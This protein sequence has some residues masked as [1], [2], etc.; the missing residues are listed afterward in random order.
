MNPIDIALQTVAPTVMV[1]RHEPF[2]PLQ[3]NGHRFLAA[4]DGLWLEARRPWLYL[5]WPLASQTKVAMPYGRLET[6]LEVVPV[7][8]QIFDQFIDM[9]Q[10]ACPLE[11]AA[12]VVWNEHTKEQ[13]LLP[14]VATSATTGSVHF[15]RPRLAEGEH[16]LLDLHSHG[17]LDAFFSGQ[18]DRD[19]RGE[20]KLSGVLGRLHRE[21]GVVGKFR[22]CANGLYV[23]LPSVIYGKKEILETL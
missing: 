19:D 14:M 15:D 17:R 21:I 16:L 7:L 1:P 4:A 10:E 20:F 11:C 23:K 8:K 3:H 5:C 2:Q 18:D 6:K 9:A 13:R 22:L 12:W